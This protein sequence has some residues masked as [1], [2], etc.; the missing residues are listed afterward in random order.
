MAGLFSPA[1]TFDE[2]NRGFR[3]KIVR[4]LRK[5]EFRAWYVVMLN[6]KLFSNGWFQNMQN[7]QARRS[8]LKAQVLTIMARPN[9]N[10]LLK[11]A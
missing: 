8:T 11:F 5:L 1:F 3:K 6:A 9:I 4:K 7:T 2:G 10:L